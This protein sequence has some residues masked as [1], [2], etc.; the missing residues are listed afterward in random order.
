M[1]SHV[2]GPRIMS[3]APGWCAKSPDHVA[4]SPMV[5]QVPRPCRRFPGWC[6]KSADH[7]AG[8]PMVCQV[9]GWCARSR[10]VVRGLA[11][12][13]DLRHQLVTGDMA[14][15]VPGP[16]ADVPG[17]WRTRRAPRMSRSRA[18]VRDAWVDVGH[19]KPR[20]RADRGVVS[21]RVPDR[22]A[23]H[24]AWPLVAANFGTR[25]LHRPDTS[26]SVTGAQTPCPVGISGRE[27]H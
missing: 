14:C 21:S 27:T 26:N 16:L 12:S 25:G 11:V 10:D 1:A 13:G 20:D 3:H 19:A 18:E 24:G 9:P 7:V 17:P 8:S 5:C 23:P 4:G 22:E 6:A 15:R 2:S